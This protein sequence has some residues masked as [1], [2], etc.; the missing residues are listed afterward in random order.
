MRLLF[1]AYYFPPTGGAGTQRSAK[2]ARDLAALGHEPV[3]VT[4]PGPT[5]STWAPRDDTLTAELPPD[6]E[7]H[8]VRAPAA[9]GRLPGSVAR[10]LDRPTAFQRWWTQGATR[11]GL[12]AAAEGAVDAVLASMS[13]Y[14]SGAAAATLAREL[15][16]PWVADLR[17]PWAL[18]EMRAY[19]SA[20]HRRRDVA[21][22]R[23]VLGT[24]SAIVMNTPE[25][26]LRLRERLPEL[27]DA[28]VVHVPNG[29]D[30]GDFAAEPAPREDDAFRIVHTGSLHTQ[31]GRDRRRARLR[32]L[33]GGSARIDVLARSHVFLLEAVRRLRELEPELAAGV[34]V[35][36]AGNLTEADR[37]AAGE[38]AVL[39]GYL[40]HADSVALLRTAD[41]LFLPM[42]DLPAGQ[43]ASIVPGKTYEY[44][45]AG[46]PILA[47]VPDGDARDL[48]GGSPV[49][50]LCR[51]RD[52]E[53][54]AEAIREE[55][56]LVRAGGRR[57][58][59][60]P[61]EIERFE[62]GR[63]AADLAGV[64]ERIVPERA[65]APEIAA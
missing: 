43:R 65:D 33:L 17:D 12:E 26:V 40:A 23:A 55:L 58:D 53:A 54:M 41:L 61:A 10:W 49:A 28:V 52:V 29:W 44:L 13:P 15:G 63:L 56:R 20:L 19:P 24:A 14:E 31:S 64:L 8:R 51:P 25:A 16:V 45:A 32:R 37:A 36:L 42:H 50:H 60:W 57:A 30:A 59:A 7:I 47:A 46:R 39:H 6:I 35:H 18:D 22:M 2:F 34:E 9:G 38:S 5:G 27:R 48:L 1:L 62:R 3:V 11:A 21:R 4:G